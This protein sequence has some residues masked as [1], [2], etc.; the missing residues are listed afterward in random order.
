MNF[1]E[2]DNIPV[3]FVVKGYK[4]LQ[5]IAL[6]LACP[7]ADC[8]NIL[9]KVLW[10]MSTFLVLPTQNVRPIVLRLLAYFFHG[11]PPQIQDLDTELTGEVISSHC[12]YEIFNSLLSP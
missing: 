12:L 9:E 10:K 4:M 1:Q 8:F 5:S 6:I 2:L 3:L 11:V 7:L